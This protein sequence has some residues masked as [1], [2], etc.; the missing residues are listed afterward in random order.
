MSENDL[1]TLSVAAKEFGVYRITV[2]EVAQKLGIVPK[3][4]T[5][6]KAKGLNRDD[7]RKL[8]KVLG[9]K[10]ELANAS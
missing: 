2:S 1:T 6:G 5:N 3:P 10:R 4:M 7:M 8:R 9:D